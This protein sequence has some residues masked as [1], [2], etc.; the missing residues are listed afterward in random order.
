[1][2][3]MERDNGLRIPLTHGSAARY[4][5]GCRCDVCMTVPMKRADIKRKKAIQGMPRKDLHICGLCGR[6]YPS[7][8]SLS[9]HEARCEW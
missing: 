9:V 6:E 1:M 5:K 7:K 2:S 8:Q 4:R 3:L